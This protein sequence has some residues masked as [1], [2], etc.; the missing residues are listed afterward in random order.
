MSSSRSKTSPTTDRGFVSLTSDKRVVIQ[1]HR[2]S[3]ICGLDVAVVVFHSCFLCVQQGTRARAN[4]CQ[5]PLEVCE[6][7]LG[8]L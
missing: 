1:A 2:K 7:E 8:A 3:N 4:D 5:L 6:S